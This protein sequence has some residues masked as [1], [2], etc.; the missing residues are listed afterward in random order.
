M[1]VFK[2][3]TMKV[4]IGSNHPDCNLIRMEKMLEKLKLMDPAML[5]VDI[6]K[7][8]FYGRRVGWV[9]LWNRHKAAYFH[10]N[11]ITVR[12]DRG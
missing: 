4:F 9:E 7:I 10:K 3:T 11:A 2:E 12:I 1:S 6:P 5:I 8:Y